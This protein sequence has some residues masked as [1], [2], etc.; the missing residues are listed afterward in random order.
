MTYAE[1]GKGVGTQDQTE[2]VHAIGSLD[3][4]GDQLVK[5][6]RRVRERA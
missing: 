3:Q 4:R 2:I 1:R 5:I 6:D